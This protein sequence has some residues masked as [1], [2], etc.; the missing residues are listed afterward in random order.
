[1]DLGYCFSGMNNKNLTT[2]GLVLIT[3]G[4]VDNIRNIPSLAL[5]NE[6]LLIY[7]VLAATLF[8]LPTAIVSGFLAQHSHSE[9]GLFGWVENHLGKRAAKNVVILQWL[10]NVCCF[11]AFLS[12]I[13]ATFL[14]LFKADIANSKSLLFILMVGL[15][16][17][18]SYLNLKDLKQSLKLSMFFT[19]IGLILPFI[20]IAI[21]GLLGLLTHQISLPPMSLSFS[22]SENQWP[23]LVA[24]MLSFCGIEIAGGLLYRV[25]NPK[26]AYPK[27]IFFSVLIIFF[28]L[29]FATMIVS[30][31]LNDNDI[32]LASGTIHTINVLLKHFHLEL[33]IPIITLLIV[34][35]SIACTNN[36]L[37]APLE[38]LNFALKFSNDA[39]DNNHCYR[40][41]LLLM[42]ALL[43]TALCVLFLC[44]SI[45]GAYWLLT[46]MAT[47]IYMLMYLLLFIA[48]LK[49][50]MQ[51]S[52]KAYW[53]VWLACF[54][55]IFSTLAT[56]SVGFIPPKLIHISQGS[57]IFEIL[58]AFLLFFTTTNYLL[59]RYQYQIKD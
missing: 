47:Q 50:V 45:N 6:H 26:K 38:N 2:I 33:F 58:L 48:A 1:M 43:V 9:R 14:T 40:R 7:F 24:V 56:I 23:I 54:M 12:F 41:P 35:G 15:F 44:S 53:H 16:S 27:A 36:W 22:H 13:V 51:L 30:G 17:T 5:L 39:F 59:R 3:V 4:S 42:Q 8:L 25:K 46:V 49:K 52:I 31:A 37:L 11:P 32:N 55:G 10:E 20:L 29:L 18:L 34:L 21:F 28:S 19:T 57:F